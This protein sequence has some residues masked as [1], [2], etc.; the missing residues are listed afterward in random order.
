MHIIDILLTANCSKKIVSETKNR[1]FLYTL[2]VRPP[3]RLT[4]RHR[5]VIISAL[6]GN[7]TDIPAV[8]GYYRRE[9]LNVEKE[10]KMKKK[11]L[12]LA[13]VC[14][15]LA[16]AGCNNNGQAGGTTAAAT[17]TTAATTTEAATTTT[18]AALETTT[19]AATEDTEALTDPAPSMDGVMTHEEYIAA[20]LD[21][22]VTVFT[23]I[24]GKQGWWEDNGVGQASFYGQDNPEGGYF[25]YNMPCSKEEYDAI[26]PGTKLKISG[27]KSEWSGEVEITDA[28]FEMFVND[29]FIATPHDVTDLLGKDELINHQNELVSFKGM[30][31]EAKK[32]ADG[33]DHSF[34][35]KWDNSGEQGDDLYFDVSKDGNT[36]TFTVESYLCGKDTDVYKAVEALQVG[37]VIDLEGF[38]YWYN[39]ANPHITNV[40][41]A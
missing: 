2:P 13:A 41:K 15:V 20:E 39:G 40:T 11:I 3:K 7:L 24:Q 18:T 12:A 29:E 27:Y 32:D 6:F 4:K 21:T 26:V 9:T 37:D 25:I 23:Y 33:N 35:Y 8:S 19:E 14:A 17:T 22:P 5:C 10:Q 36:Y 30:T 16:A 31:V 34:M 1:S 38:L 28:T